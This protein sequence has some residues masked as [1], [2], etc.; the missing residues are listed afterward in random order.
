MRF[1]GSRLR[2]RDASKRERTRVVAD[3][4]ALQCTKGVTAGSAGGD[5]CQKAAE[6]RRLIPDS[7]PSVEES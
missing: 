6:T 3:G 2:H 7:P 4:D 1:R 5:H